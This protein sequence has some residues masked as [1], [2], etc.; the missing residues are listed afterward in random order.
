MT[1][2]KRKPQPKPNPQK[3]SFQSMLAGVLSVLG[4]VTEPKVEGQP[5][6]ELIAS[7][8]RPRTQPNSL[9]RLVYF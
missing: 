5:C 4:I 1:G 7:I 3:S 6:R 8:P 9:K 2:A